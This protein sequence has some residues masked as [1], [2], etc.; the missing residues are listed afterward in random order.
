MDLNTPPKRISKKTVLVG[1]LVLTVVIL[2]TFGTILKN[3]GGKD[4]LGTLKGIPPYVIPLCF[5]MLLAFSFFEGVNMHRA[6][7]LAGYRGNLLQSWKYAIAGFFYSGITPSS[8]GGQPMQ[9][10]YMYQDRVKISHGLFA[11]IMQL[12]GHEGAIVILGLT[13]FLTMRGKMLQ[14]AGHLKFLIFLGLTLNLLY[15]LFLMVVLFTRRGIEI[16]TNVLGNIVGK[17]AR[18]G[19]GKLVEKIRSVLDD[20]KYVSDY[21]K[22]DRNIAWKAILT[23]LLQF[24]SLFSIQALIYFGL[25]LSEYNYF[26]IILLQSVVFISVGFIPIPGSAGISE[27]MSMLLY[28]II[29]P[30][31]LLG[32]AVLLGRCFSMY[33]GIILYGTILA[34]CHIMS[35]KHT[36]FVKKRIVENS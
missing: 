17:F 3:L 8:S 12:F 33:F 10:Y 31:S 18:K 9:I 6:L 20:Y 32:G 26:Q 34:V 24:I 29:Y 1:I 14:P 30:M 13:G 35:V 25:G 16:T 15:F 4:I 36:S 22:K 7:R 5:F 23:G 11:V 19:K 2:L 27:G 21:L 28:Q